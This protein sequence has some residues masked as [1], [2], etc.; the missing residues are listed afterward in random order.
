MLIV[1]PILNANTNRLKDGLKKFD[2][3]ITFIFGEFDQSIYYLPLLENVNP[4][5]EIFVLKDIDH[6]FKDNVELF[7][8]LPE[9]YLFNK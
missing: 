4:L 5:A 9:K 7:I 2:G 8:E 1:N 6:I 3:D